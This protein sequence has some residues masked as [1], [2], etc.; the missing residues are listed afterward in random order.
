MN[1]TIKNPRGLIPL[2]DGVR[3]REDILAYVTRTYTHTTRSFPDVCVACHLHLYDHV[4]GRCLTA[5]TRF[6]EWPD[7]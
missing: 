4:D 3:T 5:P 1:P 6:V 7:D 2:Q